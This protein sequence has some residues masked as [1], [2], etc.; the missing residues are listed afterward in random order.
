MT[1]FHIE[2]PTRND[3]GWTCR[4]RIDAASPY[5]DG[6]F[7]DHPVL[8]GV[9]QMLLVEDVLQRCVDSTVIVAFP[10]MRLRRQIAPD[11][12][13]A[14]IIADRDSEGQHAFRIHRDGQPV[15]TGRIL[16]ADGSTQ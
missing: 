5:F 1:S 12:E 4:V 9:A 16:A 6:H 2:T 15:T 13:L 8:P 7:P 10:Q 14:V 11:D 3:D